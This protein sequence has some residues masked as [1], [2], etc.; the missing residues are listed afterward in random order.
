MCVNV[1]E[2][3]LKSGRN[4]IYYCKIIIGWGFYPVSSIDYSNFIYCKNCIN[5]CLICSNYSDYS[6]KNITIKP[7]VCFIIIIIIRVKLF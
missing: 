5:W 7:N 1:P 6:S 4:L 3:V 2:A